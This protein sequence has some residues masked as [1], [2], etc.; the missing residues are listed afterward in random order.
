MLSHSANLKTHDYALLC[1]FSSLPNGD[2]KLE[3]KQV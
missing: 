3:R 2:E 1:R